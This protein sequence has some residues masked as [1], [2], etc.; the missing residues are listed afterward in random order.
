METHTKSRTHT[1]HCQG[2]HTNHCRH[3]SHQERRRVPQGRGWQGGMA[4]VPVVGGRSCAQELQEARE[5]L[6]R[7]RELTSSGSTP[8]RTSRSPGSVTATPRR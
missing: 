6:A 7:L 5:E 4:T 3:G 8:P 2:S 1:N